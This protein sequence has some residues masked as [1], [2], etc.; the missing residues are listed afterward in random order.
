MI[1][2]GNSVLTEHHA[3][4]VGGVWGFLKRKNGLCRRADFL[5]VRLRRFLSL[6]AMGRFRAL[7]CEWRA[8]DAFERMRGREVRDCG[9]RAV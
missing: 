1:F 5:T 6:V 7:V 3:A 4:A 9:S 8:P 2:Q